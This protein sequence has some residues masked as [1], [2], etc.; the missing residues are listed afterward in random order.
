MSFPSNPN[1]GQQH[2]V[3]NRIYVWSGRVWNLATSG[4]INPFDQSL[5]TTD[6]PT[7]DSVQAAAY[8]LPNNTAV[9]AGTYDNNLGGNGG[10]SL[11]CS[12]GYE[13][14]WQAG[15]LRNIENGGTPQA[16]TAPIYCDSSLI[17][18]GN[19]SHNMTVSKTGILFP[20]GTTQTSAASGNGGEA[21][22]GDGTR[23]VVCRS[24]DNLA[25]KYA[26]ATNLNP[27]GLAKSA[28]NRA[29]LII[30]PGTYSLSQQLIIYENYVDVIGLGSIRKHRGCECGV[31]ITGSTVHVTAQHVR[32]KG[33][34]VGAQRFMGGLYS[35]QIFEECVGGDFSFAENVP[36]NYSTGDYT[37]NFSA[38]T[39][40]NCVGGNYSFGCNYVSPNAYIN[41][42]LM[43]GAYGFFQNCVAGENSFGGGGGGGYY[44]FLSPAIADGE[45]LNC[46]A[47][48]YSFGGASPYN[49]YDRR[50]GGIFVDCV[51]SSYCFGAT[52]PAIVGWR[53]YPSGPSGTFKN[54][55]GSDRFASCDSGNGD[56]IGTF[57]GCTGRVGSW[58][59]CTGGLLINCRLIYG[60]FNAAFGTY[61][62]CLNEDKSIVNAG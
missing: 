21:L 12:V 43:G 7:F 3:D 59:K 13:L 14:N 30:M 41:N 20:D 51:G 35:T 1:V 10:L 57:I 39:Y 19:G 38:G 29:T 25:T 45:F 42:S 48:N 37:S 2:T 24:G 34:S 6:A 46:Q 50:A 17:L 28:T 52:T 58:G 54:C 47:A 40:I 49:N 15:R 53:V 33:I 44:S 62:F 27:G 61:R 8:Q 31:L 4:D 22:E 60:S 16:V 23:Y 32:I 55:A 18:P 9:A 26:A 5:N 36:A 56:S 11:Y